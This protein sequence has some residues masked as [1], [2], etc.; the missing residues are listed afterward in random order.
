[1][2]SQ[3]NS[4]AGGENIITAETRARPVRGRSLAGIKCANSATREVV[5]MGT[6]R[7]ANMNM[8]FNAPYCG[9]F[10]FIAYEITKSTVNGP[11][12]DSMRYVKS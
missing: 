4:F 5:A 9:V 2:E 10:G 7:L 3:V 6:K 1:L 12:K 11:S 8:Y